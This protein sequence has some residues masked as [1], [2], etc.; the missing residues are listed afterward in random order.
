MLMV[1]RSDPKARVVPEQCTKHKITHQG[2]GHQ[3][4]GHQ[5]SGHQGSGRQGSLFFLA[6]TIHLFNFVGP[7]STS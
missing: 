1:H 2:S 3:G 4:S 6:V 7:S 5:G